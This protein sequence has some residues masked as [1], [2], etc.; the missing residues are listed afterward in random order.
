[1]ARVSVKNAWELNPEATAPIQTE[2]RTQ[3]ARDRLSEPVCRQCCLATW[4]LVRSQSPFRSGLSTYCFCFCLSAFFLPPP[5]PLVSSVR[6]RIVIWST[7]T[8]LVALLFFIVAGEPKFKRFSS[9]F[10]IF[11]WCCRWVHFFI[12][13]LTWSWVVV[14]W[15]YQGQAKERG[16]REEESA[17]G[18]KW[19]SENLFTNRMF[20]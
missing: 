4:L 5:V 16:K 19:K 6:P 14:Q 11:Y 1:M 2:G 13:V 17:E 12:V 18:E 8:C 20:P 3:V 9:H 10:F 15:P 7:V